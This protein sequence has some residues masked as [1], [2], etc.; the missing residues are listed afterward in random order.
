MLLLLTVTSAPLAAVAGN[1]LTVCVN[2]LRQNKDRSGS[3]LKA[4]PGGHPPDECAKLCAAAKSSTDG[5]STCVGF[6]TSPTNQCWLKSGWNAESDNVDRDNVEMTQACRTELANSREPICPTYYDQNAG[7]DTATPT[8]QLGSIMRVVA[9]VSDMVRAM[10]ECPPLCA[11]DENCKGYV[12]TPW[13]Q[14]CWPLNGW[15]VE[16]FLVQTGVHSMQMVTAC[17]GKFIAKT[18]C[19]LEEGTKLPG[20]TL[21]DYTGHDLKQCKRECAADAN[22]K[23]I[24]HQT[25]SSH[26]FLKNTL[27]DINFP[28]TEVQDANYNSLRMTAACRMAVLFPD[29]RNYPNEDRWGAGITQIR[30]L[31]K[32]PDM[33]LCAVLCSADPN[34]RG[35]VYRKE[36]DHCWHRGEAEDSAGAWESDANRKPT[37]GMESLTVGGTGANCRQALEQKRVVAL[38]G[39]D[40]CQEGQHEDRW[41]TGITGIRMMQNVASMTLCA[42]LCSADPNCLGAVTQDGND[43]CFHRGEATAGAWESDANRKPTVGMQSLTVGGTGANCRQALEKKRVV[44]L[45]DYDA[46]QEGHHEDRWGTGITGIRMLQNVASMTICAVLCSADPNCLGAVTQDGNDNCFHRGEATAGAWESDAN[47]RPTLG[48]QSLTVGGTG[49][50]CR[51]ALEQKRVAALP[52]Y[53]A[54]LEG[55]HEDRHGGGI[56]GIRMVHNVAS[57]TLCATLCAADP[58]CHGA[59]TQDG[60][61][62]CWHRGEASEGAWELDANRKPSVGMQS[63]TVEGNCRNEIE[64]QRLISLPEYGA[65]VERHHED[66]HGGGITGLRTVHNVPN[67]T[68]CATLC[69][70]DPNCH[71]AVTQDGNQYCWHRGEAIDSAGAWGLDANRKPSVGVQSVTVEGNC[72]HEIQEKRVGELPVF[73]ACLEGEQGAECRQALQ[74]GEHASA[75]SGFYGACS[76]RHHEDRH[77]GGITGIR[78]MHNVAN[79]TLCATLCAADPNCHGSA[80]R[81]F[82]VVGMMIEHGGARSFGH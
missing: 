45:P 29:C 79:V 44:A 23:G 19:L 65:C 28:G 58:N 80:L 25:S 68:V 73:G 34:C 6:V 59:V 22:C 46:C 13:D 55:K 16:P 18:P 66:R 2:E 60:N 32:V 40:A 64:A 10:E 24:V 5:S 76:E 31:Q 33:G 36:D 49:A 72:R 77:G 51:H 43:N 81:C 3:D 27:A 61:Q 57:M 9:G 7:W 54:C 67:M 75:L 1:Q 41:G 71:G 39:Y 38:P 70:A 63:V 14:K 50:N 82:N 56:T 20:T 78:T 42:V 21:K 8:K 4:L 11:A 30:M 62:N 12:F 74:E 37:A 15:D 35:A 69:A 53:G 17:R 47:R 26:C 48:M 52:D